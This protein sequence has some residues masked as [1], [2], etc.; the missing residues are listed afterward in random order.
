M[1]NDEKL[2]SYKNL[3]KKDEIKEILKHILNYKNIQFKEG[4]NLIKKITEI[5]NKKNICLSLQKELNYYK[6][7]N[8]YLKL[9]LMII[10]NKKKENKYDKTLVEQNKNKIDEIFQSRKILYENIMKKYIL[11]IEKLKIE[12]NNIIEKYSP[13]LNQKKKDNKLLIE[14]NKEQKNEINQHN[15]IIDNINNNKKQLELK[16]KKEKIELTEKE[17]I[18]LYKISELEQK[19]KNFSYY[20]VP[21]TKPILDDS[22]LSNKIITNE[23]LNITLREKELENQNLQL[24]ISR[25]ESKIELSKRRNNSISQ[26]K[27]FS[28]YFLYNNSPLKKSFNFSK[29]IRLEK[30]G[31]SNSV[32]LIPHKRKNSILNLSISKAHIHNQ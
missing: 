12:K 11:Q 2:N 23:N 6:E 29:K 13:I 31:F 3:G 15:K 32:I 22:S 8:S 20:H 28:Q 30:T 19:I 26:D 10:K 5:Q 27:N 16:K 25:L 1:R 17:E 24:T 7:L 18:L 4:K 9:N 21:I 14:E